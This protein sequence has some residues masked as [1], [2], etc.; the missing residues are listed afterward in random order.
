MPVSVSLCVFDEFCLLS[1]SQALA[2]VPLMGGCVLGSL[3]LKVVR[4]S[5]FLVG[6]AAGGVLGLYAYNLGVRAYSD[7]GASIDWV[8]WACLGVPALAGGLQCYRNGG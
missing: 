4:L 7:G 3:A 8:Y 2:V 5:F 1:L 6:A